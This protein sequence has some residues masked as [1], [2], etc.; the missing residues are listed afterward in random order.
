MSSK[1]MTRRAFLRASALGAAG[2]A[3]VAC[4]PQTVFVDREVTKEVITEVTKIVTEIETK[5]VEVTV[6]P[7]EVKEAP[8]LFTQVA[9]G[10]LPPVS[11]RMP[12]DVRVVNVTVSIGT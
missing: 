8:D 5:V 12:A 2:A 1:L 7:E 3:V 9:Q 10:K 11:E 6:A 4:Q